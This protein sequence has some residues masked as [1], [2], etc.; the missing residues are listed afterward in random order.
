MQG[1]YKKV[2]KTKE[3]Q[4]NKERKP[5]KTQ[6]TEETPNPT[7]KTQSPQRT[8]A[9]LHNSK[10]DLASNPARTNTPSI[11]IDQAF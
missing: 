5:K 4:K 3:K 10:G 7:T 11:E 9:T 2:T 1:V 8:W 6:K